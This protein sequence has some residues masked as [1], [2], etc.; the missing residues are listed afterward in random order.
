[1][2]GGHNS[3]WKNDARSSVD[4][5]NWDQENTSSVWVDYGAESTAVVFD[6]KI[7]MLGGWQGPNPGTL[8]NTIRNSSDGKTWQ[9]ITPVGPIG[10]L[11]GIIRQSYLITRFGSLGAK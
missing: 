1:M 3:G 7:W 8:I 5:T 10:N 11:D 4:G 2:I 6:G 9:T